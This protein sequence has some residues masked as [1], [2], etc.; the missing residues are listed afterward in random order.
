[1]TENH[2]CTCE[3]CPDHSWWVRSRDRQRRVEATL[4]SL[5]SRAGAEKAIAQAETTIAR[6]DRENHR[7]PEQAKVQRQRKALVAKDE[8]IKNLK[9]RLVEA[10]NEAVATYTDP[11]DPECLDYEALGAIFRTAWHMA[12][13]EGRE[14]E[15]VTDGLRAVFSW[16]FA[17]D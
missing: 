11:I 3:E 2:V 13:D 7:A 8:E 4:R 17:N 6:L 15:R 16:W 10:E 1:M 14:G 5:L 9:A 12:D